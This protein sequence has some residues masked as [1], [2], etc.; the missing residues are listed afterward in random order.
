MSDSQ[1]FNYSLF[2]RVMAMVKPYKR[3]FYLTAALTVVLAPL[4]VLRPKLVETMV[5]NYIVTGDVKG[6]T[7]IA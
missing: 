6:M 4:A 3:T 2:R 5:D 7:I 1:K